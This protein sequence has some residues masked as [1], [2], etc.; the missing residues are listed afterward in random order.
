MC[1]RILWNRGT[2]LKVANLL[3]WNDGDYVMF[4][5]VLH[6][7]W[8]VRPTILRL[9]CSSAPATRNC[10]TG[11]VSALFFTKCWLASHLSLPALP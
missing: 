11:G 9:R 10:V 1:G 3:C 8:S 7:H 4:S 5:A 6:T 2:S